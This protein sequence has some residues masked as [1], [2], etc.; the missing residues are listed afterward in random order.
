MKASAYPSL[1]MNVMFYQQFRYCQMAFQGNNKMNL[2]KKNC[3]ADPP[4]IK[5]PSRKDTKK[6]PVIMRLGA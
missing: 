2:F 6:T 4:D 1:I 3:G 5:P